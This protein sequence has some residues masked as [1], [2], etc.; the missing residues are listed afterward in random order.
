MLERSVSTSPRKMVA[1]R[2]TL[3]RCK[4]RPKRE[5]SSPSRNSEHL[6]SRRDRT[7]MLFRCYSSTIHT[8]LIDWICKS[9]RRA[10][11]PCGAYRNSRGQFGYKPL[12]LGN[13]IARRSKGLEAV[14][15]VGRLPQTVN[16]FSATPHRSR[17]RI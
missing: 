17:S 2:K 9:S 3:L 16:F 6:Q 14:L 7:A 1:F 4:D 8:V 15:K 11:R 5:A 13:D 12:P 10:R